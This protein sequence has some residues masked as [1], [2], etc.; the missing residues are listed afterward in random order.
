MNGKKHI[1]IV[2]DDEVMRTLIGDLAQQDGFIVSTVA[3]NAR[4]SCHIHDI[5]CRR[6]VHFDRA[7]HAREPQDRRHQSPNE[8]E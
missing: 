5:I 1:L 8:V 7:D 4:K 2:D 3:R 6:D